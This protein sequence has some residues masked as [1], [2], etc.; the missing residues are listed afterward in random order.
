MDAAQLGRTALDSA[1]ATLR[2]AS[3][4]VNL[5]DGLLGNRLE[6]RVGNHTRLSTP[7][8]ECVSRMTFR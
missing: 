7:F 5:P 4:T 3:F 6:S 2:T 1:A 8:R